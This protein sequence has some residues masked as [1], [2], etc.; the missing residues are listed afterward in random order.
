[1]VLPAFAGLDEALSRMSGAKVGAN[2]G[3]KIQRY[4]L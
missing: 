3:N 1:M 4:S 2:L